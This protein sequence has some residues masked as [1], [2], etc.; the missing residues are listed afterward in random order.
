MEEKD[1]NESNDETRARGVKRTSDIKIAEV[2][3]SKKKRA[4]K[5]PAE[6]PEPA[7]V[8]INFNDEVKQSEESAKR[9]R[10]FRAVKD[11]ANGE[12][13]MEELTKALHDAVADR[14][15]RLIAQGAFH[16]VPEKPRV[17]ELNME[18]F[19]RSARAIANNRE[20]TAALM[21]NARP[22]SSS[23]INPVVLNS[24]VGGLD[25][26]PPIAEP[27]LLASTP[28][29]SA[30]TPRCASEPSASVLTTVGA[31]TVLQSYATPSSVAQSTHG[32][33]PDA[34]DPLSIP[35]QSQH[36]QAHSA[37]FSEPPSTSQQ[38]L[39]QLSAVQTNHG[40][41]RASYDSRTAA[42]ANLAAPNKPCRTGSCL[43]Q[44]QSG[45]WITHYGRSQHLPA[46]CDGP[47]GHSAGVW[48]T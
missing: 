5:P 26:S 48:I 35:V 18:A 12:I 29:L 32:Q 2:T 33:R 23:E 9:S 47:S 44:A 13:S 31:H 8:Q 16:N 27:L 34:H 11:V 41:H 25:P 6:A 4:E 46:I 28:N 39:P 17:I 20:R 24:S 37:A 45:Q 42:P 19:N 21:R 38:Q 1:F 3:T 30:M 7:Q 22:L 14:N 43:V 40:Q 10:M 15:L 36:W